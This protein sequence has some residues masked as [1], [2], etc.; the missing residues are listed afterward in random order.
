MHDLLG[1]AAVHFCPL[2]CLYQS[3]VL[4]SSG[5]LTAL[6]TAPEPAAGLPEYLL[7]SSGNELDRTWLPSPPPPRNQPLAHQSTVLVSSGGELDRTCLPSPH[8]PGTSRWQP[9]TRVR[10]IYRSGG[11]P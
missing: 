6:A 10:Y 4:V 8:R 9:F 11:M 3:T 1:P 7:V 5:N 2:S